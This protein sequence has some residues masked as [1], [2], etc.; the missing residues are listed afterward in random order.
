MNGSMNSNENSDE[1]SNE[2]CV[3]SVNADLSIAPVSPADLDAI[4]ALVLAVARTDIFPGLSEEGQATFLNRVLPDIE[5]C[6]VSSNFFAIKACQA[7]KLLGFAALRDGNY[8]THLFVDKSV[9]G[10]GLGKALLRSVLCKSSSGE[11]SLRSSVNAVPFYERQGFYATGPEAQVNG[12]RFVP[13]S[14][15]RE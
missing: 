1:H 14:L 4:T 13:M 3:Q 12:I 11:L 10:A 9:Q 8:L 2:S 7:G 5:T 15:K 6:F